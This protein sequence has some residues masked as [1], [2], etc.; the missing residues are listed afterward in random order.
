MGQ[1]IASVFKKYA[2]FSG[3]ARRSEYWYF[4]LF[5]LLIAIVF[6]L[7]EFL[8][9]ESRFTQWL[10][11]LYSVATLLP[12]LA[13][14]WRRLH[15]IGKSGGW[16]FF[17]YIILAAIALILFVS[18]Q[19]TIPD[20][21]GSTILA[22]LIFGGAALIIWIIVFIV[23]LA[24]NGQPGENEYGPDPK[25]AENDTNDTNREATDEIRFCRECGEPLEPGSAFCRH[26]GKKIL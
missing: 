3:R 23:W 25:E 15:D 5:N 12:G 22:I 18:G 20:S 24:T 6:A 17:V 26:C 4:F 14:S 11:A 21:D 2:V 9:G 19:S 16:T 1:A 13:V 8:T 10:S 7:L